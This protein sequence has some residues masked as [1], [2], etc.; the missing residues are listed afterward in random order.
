[1]WGGWG[2]VTDDLEWP[3]TTFPEYTAN[4][5]T[6]SLVFRSGTDLISLLIFFFLLFVGAT[7]SEKSKAPSFQIGSGWNLAGMFFKEIHYDWC[8]LASDM[9][10][11]FQDG[12]HDVILHR[13]VLPPGECT[14]G[15]C[16][17]VRQFLIYSIFV[18]VFIIG[19]VIWCIS[20]AT[21][22]LLMLMV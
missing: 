4:I 21:T 19:Y 1:M 8:T 14:H 5:P 13:K 15:I 9:P 10:S 22:L 7:S 16:R 12:G 2:N 11:Q 17:D 18:L 6:I 20:M 3:W